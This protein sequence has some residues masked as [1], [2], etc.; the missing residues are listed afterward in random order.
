M[1]RAALDAARCTCCSRRTGWRGWSPRIAKEYGDRAHAGR[2][3][4]P[5]RADERVRRRLRDRRHDRARRRRARRLARRA[6]ARG[7]LHVLSEAERDGSTCLPVAELAAARRRAARRIARRR[8]R[9][10]RWPERR[11]AGARGRRARVWAYRPETAALERELAERIRAL[12]AA[13]TPSSQ[14]PLRTSDDLVPAPEQAAAVRAAFAPRLSIVTGGPGT[15]K[16]ATIRMIC[17]AAEAAERVGR[18]GRAD[19][20]RRAADGRGDRAATPRRSTPRS[21]GSPARARPTT[22]SRPTC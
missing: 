1:G 7:V 19:R 4:A 21:A 2:A 15:G 22:S 13:P 5:V 20:P 3:R 12:A 8:A 9:S 10:R 14:P 16:T 18:A 11:A 6:H 17:A